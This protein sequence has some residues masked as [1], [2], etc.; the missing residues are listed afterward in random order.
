VAAV[1][2]R[3]LALA[4]CAIAWLAA[5]AGAAPPAAEARFRVLQGGRWGYIDAKGGLVIPP[6]F[7]RA[8]PFSEGLAAV[9]K[10]A[11]SGYV[12]AGG[13]WA[14]EP[15]QAPA[16]LEHR[17]FSNGRAV[18][19]VGGRE[20]AIDR[21]GR[22][23]IPAGSRSSTES[24]PVSQPA[25]LRSIRPGQALCWALSPPPRMPTAGSQWH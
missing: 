11:R 22:L 16:G 8:G 9:V 14:L 3:A 24:T 15:A 12:D 17:P 25:E 21:T 23:V 13:A 1:R 6:Q 19:R 4:A 20:G 7:D 10:G 2:G 18:V 5:D